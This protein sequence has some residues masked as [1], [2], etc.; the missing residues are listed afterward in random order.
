[1][2]PSRFPYK[3]GKLEKHNVLQQGICHG[4]AYV[5][6]FLRSCMHGDCVQ[7]VVLLMRN[8]LK[9]LTENKMEQNRDVVV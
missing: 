5:L 6:V 7:N 2:P 8:Y 1:M 3:W 4:L 9:M